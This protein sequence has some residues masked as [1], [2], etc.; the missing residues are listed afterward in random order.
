MSDTFAAY[1]DICG[2]ISVRPTA[3]LLTNRGV[4]HQFMGERHNAMRDY[5]AAIKQDPTYALAYFDAANMYFHMRQF[6][7]VGRLC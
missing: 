2:A 5:L 1:Q 4:I 7:Q 6:K 3:E